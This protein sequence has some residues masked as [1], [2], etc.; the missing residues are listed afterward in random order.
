MSPPVLY[1]STDRSFC[2]P[3][4]LSRELVFYD[5]QWSRLQN[6]D[7]SFCFLLKLPVQWQILHI[8]TDSH[9]RTICYF[10][11]A[12]KG[13]IFAR[14]KHY[15]GFKVPESSRLIRKRSSGTNREEKKSPRVER[16]RISISVNFYELNHSPTFVTG[17][18]QIDMIQGNRNW[19]GSKETWRSQRRVRL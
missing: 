1:S 17:C 16:N 2:L 12:P 18:K 5:P 6:I 10:N 11:Q 15:A 8:S 3:N 4:L 9:T 19:Q 7:H 14:C 13:G